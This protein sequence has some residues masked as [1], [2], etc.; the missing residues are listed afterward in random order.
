MNAHVIMHESFESPAAILDW[1]IKKNIQVSFTRLYNGDILPTNPDSYDI[2]FVMGGPQS[3]ST[4]IEECPYF[5]AQS[6]IEHIKKAVDNQKSI[7]GVC[8]GAQLI[9]EA[10]GA[11]YEHSPNREIGVFDLNLTEDAKT[12]P[13][14]SYFPNTF[15]VGHWHGDMPGLT[16]DSKVLAYSEGCP[17]QIVRYTPNIYGFQCHFEFTKTA[18]EGMVENCGNELEK[19]RDNPYVETH[20]ELLSHDFE[21]MNEKLFIFLDYLKSI[22][23]Q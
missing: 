13:V 12:D 5:D 23:K 14:F 22:I 10:L 1:C 17:R 9:G 7:L 6:E 4:T 16:Q 20:E 11:T 8:L 19:Y 21:E 2:L 18:V 3:P 15:K